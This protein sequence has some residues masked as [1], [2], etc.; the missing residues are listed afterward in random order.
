MDFQGGAFGS[1]GRL[2]LGVVSPIFM[3]SFELV[4]RLLLSC[5]FSF[6]ICFLLIFPPFCIVRSVWGFIYKA[7]ESL[8]HTSLTVAR[9]RTIPTK[10]GIFLSHGLNISTPI[11]MS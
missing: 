3:F 5:R 7:G 9:N 10:A 8:Y 4:A 1:L 6:L 2:V 11:S